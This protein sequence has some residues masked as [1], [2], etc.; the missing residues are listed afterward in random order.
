MANLNQTRKNNQQ[1]KNFLKSAPKLGIFQGVVV[2]TEDISRTGKL[3]VF[4]PALGGDKK[5]SDTYISCRWVSPF[6]GQTDLGALGTDVTNYKDTTTSY[7]MWMVP[8]DP[9]NIVLVCFGDGIEKNAFCFGCLFPD[10]YQH[11][12]PG[13]S[14]GKSYSDP[15]INVPV[16]EKN[17][18]ESH[19]THNDATRPIHVDFAKTL[20][21]QGLINDPLRGAGYASARRESPSEVFGILTPGP[22]DPDNYNKRLGGHQL[23]MDDNTNSRMIRLRTAAGSQLMLDD[24]TGTIYMINKLGTAWFELALNGDVN[25]Y[26]ESNINFRAKGDFNIRADQNVN[27]EAGQDLNLKAAGDNVAGDYKGIN[28]LGALGLPPLG[29]GG[30]IRMEAAADLSQN[31]AQSFAVT[32]T[33]G[34]MDINAGGRIAMTASGPAPLIGGIQ[35]S[36]PTGPIAIDSMLGT[37]LNST[38]GI[39][40][41]APLVSQTAGLI[42]LNSPGGMPPFPAMP[43]LTA[44]QLGTSEFKDNPKDPPQFD[45]EDV[46]ATEATGEDEDV[47]LTSLGGVK[48]KTP[49]PYLPTGGKRE[50]DS[51]KM[52]TIVSKLITSEPYRDH[53][54]ADPIKRTEQSPSADPDVES[55]L[56][57]GATEEGAQKPKN[58]QTPEGTQVGTGYKDKAGNVISDLT[59]KVQTGTSGANDV[60]N[61]VNAGLDAV[62]AGIDQASQAVSDAVGGAV[63]GLIDSAAG[64]LGMDALPQFDG[65]MGAF[66]NFSSLL[67]GDLLSIASLGGLIEGIKAVLPPIRF[68][69]I[70]ALGSK[71]IGLG[72]TLNEIQARLN[73]FG[74]DKFGFDMDLLGADMLDM[75]NKIKDAMST[76][77]DFADLGEKLKAQGISIIQ[78]GTG[79]IFQNDKT[80]SMLVDFSNGIG[81]VGASLGAVS[82]LT[83]TYENIKESVSVEL[84]EHQS[85]ATVS[86]ATS[87]GVE[88][89]LGSKALQ[90]LNNPEMHHMVPTEMQK[91][92]LD[93]PGGEIDPALQGQRQY[94][95]ELF[96]T[97]DSVELGSE[98]IRPEGSATWFMLA[99]ELEAKNDQFYIEQYQL[100]PA[101]RI[102]TRS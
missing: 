87:I 18:R 76:A 16:A 52:K 49:K 2:D 12:V 11:M 29:T 28:A 62:G 43:A 99:D 14:G 82:E 81:P 65:L 91:W 70:N 24:T 58:T 48:G 79:I 50:G 92:I 23:I 77:K 3:S 21:R 33:G 67:D 20:T 56:P 10:R 41:V 42:A 4:I 60:V 54:Q 17:R 47:E 86:F 32:A 30:N 64:A 69:T 72:K 101:T 100:D 98:V 95:A 22:R 19:I 89:F 84:S 34:D 45:E 25:V 44:P 88:N 7:G 55:K 15:S 26:S 83:N 97:P 68:P 94:E 78:D 80:G 90:Y 6:A 63:D 85:L 8:P 36:A 9:G 46:P 1:Y 57:A 37:S 5:K 102:R 38:A 53:A 71:A 61:G 66:N 35:L 13:M 59:E 27:I 39:S 74:I 96:T 31:A 51:P 75:K 40:M 93:K 73:Q